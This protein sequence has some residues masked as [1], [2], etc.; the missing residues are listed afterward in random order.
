M[1]SYDQPTQSRAAIVMRF[2][3]GFGQKY[4]SRVIFGN[5]IKKKFVYNQIER[6]LRNMMF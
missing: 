5:M 1:A 4:S 2:L 6:S 3:E